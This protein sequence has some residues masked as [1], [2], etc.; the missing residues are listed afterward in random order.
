MS[1]GRPGRWGVGVAIGLA[2]VA[3]ATGCGRGRQV[4]EE[5]VV[6]WSPERLE[7]RFPAPPEAAWEPV[8]QRLRMAF[9]A[10]RGGEA[11][12]VCYS[13]DALSDV[14]AYYAPLYGVA[15]RKVRVDREPAAG[16]FET[17]RLAAAD[18]GHRIP[19]GPTPSGAVR[20]VRF[21]QKGDLPE[22]VLQSPYLDLDSGRVRRGTLISM[23]WLPPGG[24]E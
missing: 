23:R 5:A 20:S 8:Y 12:W 13:S 21:G 16:R 10:E 17:V 1:G 7:P 2:C 4:P 15:V 24:D 22:L 11:R 6:L 14:M 9:E 19:P 18:L 3:G